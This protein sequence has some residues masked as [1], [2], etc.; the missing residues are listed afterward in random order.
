[1]KYKRGLDKGGADKILSAGLELVCAISAEDADV[2][3][4]RLENTGS[5]AL[6]GFDIKTSVARNA[7]ADS[8]SAPSW[9]EEDGL[10]V[11]RGASTSPAYLS[12]GSSVSL[13]INVSDRAELQVWAS[14]PGATLVVEA[15]LYS[16]G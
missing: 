9:T 15:G 6:T 8:I 1:M 7:E 5:S 12:A 13:S 11:T 14:G 3:A 2:I 10:I 16:A 4:L